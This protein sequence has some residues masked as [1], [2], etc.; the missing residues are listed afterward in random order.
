MLKVKEERLSWK[1]F[2]NYMNSYAVSPCDNTFTLSGLDGLLGL[3]NL[4]ILPLFAKW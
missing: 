1:S 4:Q 2:S 3:I